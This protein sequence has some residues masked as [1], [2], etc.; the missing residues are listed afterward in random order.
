MTA[1]TTTAVRTLKSKLPP[2]I[3]YGQD[4]PKKFKTTTLLLLIYIKLNGGSEQTL[5]F[6]K[7]NKRKWPAINVFYPL[8][9]LTG[10]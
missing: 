1:A 2:S 10:D 8:A 7:K 4:Y 9:I 5:A 3:A 6:E